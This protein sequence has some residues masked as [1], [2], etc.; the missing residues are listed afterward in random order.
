MVRVRPETVRATSPSRPTNGHDR[1]VSGAS[2]DPVSVV[3]GALIAGASGGVSASASAAVQGAYDALVGRLRAL[4]GRGERAGE[5][6]A[7]EV[8]DDVVG[9]T[10]ADPAAAESRL[11]AELVA[12]GAEGDADLLAAAQRLWALLDPSAFAAGKYRVDLRGA[13]GV[14]VG[15]HNTQVVNF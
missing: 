7:G 10:Q 12:A 6:V 11:R 13:Q 1:F 8:V 15:D 5:V 2:V 4:F 9:G 14:Q 3:V